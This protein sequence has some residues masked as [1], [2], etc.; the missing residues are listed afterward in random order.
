MG[1]TKQ[2]LR[3]EPTATFGLVASHRS[4]VVLLDRHG[5]QGRCAAVGA[6][7]HVIVWDLH[8]KDKVLTLTGDKH[9]VT[10]LARSPDH[11]HLAVGYMDGSVRVFEL[12]AGTSVVT[13]HGHR[14]AVTALAYDHDGLRIASGA[15]DTDVIVWDIVSEAGLFRLKGHKGEITKVFFFK[16]KN[17]LI[18]SSKDTFVK[19]WDLDTQHCFRT[20]TGHRAEVYSFVVVNGGHRL[21][22][23]SSDSELR[24][25]DMTHRSET[26]EDLE[27]PELP[28]KHPRLTDESDEEDD[29]SSQILQCESRGSVMRQGRD[30]VVCLATDQSERYLLCHG[31]GSFCEV[32]VL[33]TE[34]ELKKKLA[35]RRKKARL[36]SEA[37]VDCDPEQPS[38]TIEDEVRRVDRFK[39]SAKLRWVD[40]ILMEP[41]RLKVVVLLN[42]NSMETVTVHVDVRTLEVQR[43]SVIHSSGHR[44]DVRTLAFSSDSAT[45]LSASAEQVKL[46]ARSNLQC[47]RTLACDY[48]LCSAF[49]PGDRNVVIGTKSGRLQVFDVDQGSM[50]GDIEAHSGALWSLCSSPDK[51]G[52]VTGSAD[53]T[54]KF[55]NYELVS[56]PDDESGRKHLTLVHTRT[57]KMD[58]DVLCV[59]YSPDQRLLAV[60]LLDNTVKVFFTDTLK[61]FL[62][63]YGHKLP[64]LCMDISSDSTLIVTGSADRNVKIW[65]LDFGDCH[66]SLFAHDDSI[67]CLQFVPKTHLFYTGGKDRKVKQWDADNFENVITLQGHHGEVWA[68]AVSPSGNFVV[69]TSHDRSIRLWE[70]S[71]EVLVL[72]EEREMEREKEYEESVAQ[73]GEPVVA[74]ETT[75]E[76]SLAGKKTIETVKA[77]E[78]LIEAVEIYS[79][80]TRKEVEHAAQCKATGKELPPPAPHPLMVAHSATSPARFVLEIIKK[81]KS[82]E[83]EEALLVL[84][85]PTATELLSILEVLLNKGWETELTC[86][87]LLFLLKIHHGQV[88]STQ[89]L[90][91]VVDRLRTQATQRTDQLK[92]LVGF[93]LMGLQ[94]LRL[95][96]EERQEVKFFADATAKFR[97]KKK[98]RKAILTITS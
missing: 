32:F 70:K 14:S 21:I 57:L 92:D 63:L 34:D 54:V 30:R 49:A 83:L 69:S 74:G 4:S 31:P 78:R 40:A 20:L 98:K 7:E 19:F 5:N 75:T 38:L 90:L 42:N 29:E 79:E 33:A 41:S 12:R 27:G 82:S 60:A 81:I 39:L 65:G 2:Y 3:V 96:M 86:R 28:T 58:E 23:G 6:C 47:I 88:T 44:S 62:S 64:V 13:F 61:F 97:E 77:A 10:V 76:V 11:S 45:I 85:F 53:N 16:G 25:W 52:I 26:D 43:S 48:A 46:W 89:V 71:Q 8:T 50:V 84:P 93:N 9:E 72:E 22:T 24:I 91:P 67:M 37:G 1:V 95:R 94:M 15:K 35:K 68:L 18:S 55:W 17:I 80:E 73:G 56:S 51:R 59:K 66:R 87:C 36:R